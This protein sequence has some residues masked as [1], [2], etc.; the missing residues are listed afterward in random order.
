L[1]L[2]TAI[3]EVKDLQ[4]ENEAN[5]KDL[6]NLGDVKDYVATRIYDQ[7]QN[8]N[9]M[10]Q[11]LKKNED[12]LANNK[13]QRLPVN[14]FPDELLANMTEWEACRVEIKNLEK[15]EKLID[16]GK[17]PECGSEISGSHE[18]FNT[19]K[20]DLIKMRKSY[21]DLQ[22]AS[23]ELRKKDEDMK[24]SIED[25]SKANTEWKMVADRCERQKES[26]ATQ[27]EQ[28]EARKRE[29]MD[30]Y[31]REIKNYQKT[32]DHIE[33]QI[34]RLGKDING[35]ESEL[36]SNKV[37]ETE[38]ISSVEQSIRLTEHRKAEEE[39]LVKENDKILLWNEEAKKHNSS[40]QQ[41]E[42]EDVKDLDKLN[43]SKNEVQQNIIHIEASKLFLKRDFPNYAI[44]KSAKILE[45]KMNVFIAK[46]YTS[47]NYTVRIEST[48]TGI[49]ILYGHGKK[50]SDVRMASGYEG[51]LFSFAYK[52]GMSSL[53]GNDCFILDELD[54]DAEEDNSLKL[55]TEI[56][57]R[58]G[59]KKQMII[60]THKEIVQNHLLDTYRAKCFNVT[61]GEI[62]EL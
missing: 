18:H 11:D 7:E 52:A 39:Q 55:F 2:T 46:T 16:L 56:A 59:V 54:A 28:L 58:F 17:C 51:A 9:L 4:E 25:I 23:T 27:E 40:I 1:K 42:K 8:V 26:L 14:S 36:L 62:N 30:E 13:L 47:R 35:Y 60:I 15:K 50:A 57:E 12:Y 41:Q 21:D 53:Y 3:K 37:D 24:K 31:D 48:K 19:V 45:D 10:R 5:K 61:Y 49:K 20:E 44:T 6:E 43:D 22:N 38:T 29:L 33:S 34:N 32:F